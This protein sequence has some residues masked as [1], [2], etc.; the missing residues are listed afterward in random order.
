[1]E[2]ILLGNEFQVGRFG[3]GW[4][5][6]VKPEL[7][8]V[9]YL[10]RALHS[11]EGVSRRALRSRAPFSHPAVDSNIYSSDLSLRS[12]FREFLTIQEILMLKH[13]PGPPD[14]DPHQLLSPSRPF[15]KHNLDHNLVVGFQDQ[16]DTRGEKRRPKTAS[17]QALLP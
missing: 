10:L 1:M 12:A 8:Q 2:V 13:K 15:I 4:G 6:V 3:C 9:V 16:P 17:Q 7:R 14:R 11:L 5:R